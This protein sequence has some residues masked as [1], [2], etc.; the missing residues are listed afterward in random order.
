VEV[1]QCLLSSLDGP[2]FGSGDR[3]MDDAIQCL[4][5][6][7]ALPKRVLMVPATAIDRPGQGVECEGLFI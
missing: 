3:L 5:H 6:G 7:H 4:A 2:G 1:D